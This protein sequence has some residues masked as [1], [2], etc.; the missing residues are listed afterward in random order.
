MY[1]TFTT[2]TFDKKI[3]ELFFISSKSHLSDVESPFPLRRRRHSLTSISGN[4]S[5]VIGGKDG[6]GRRGKAKEGDKQKKESKSAWGKVG[7]SHV[8]SCQLCLLSFKLEQ[9]N[10]HVC[11]GEAVLEFHEA[12][13]EIICH[14]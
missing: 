8:L 1:S 7:R 3:F 14:Y 11:R 2:C 4:K 5:M 9:R 13:Q 12:K 6:G 10:S